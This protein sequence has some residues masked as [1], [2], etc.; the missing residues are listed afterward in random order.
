MERIQELLSEED[1]QKLKS[2][3]K[4]RSLYKR[5][6]VRVRK[7]FGAGVYGYDPLLSDDVIEGFGV[8]AL[9]IAMAAEVLGWAPVVGL[10]VGLKETIRYFEKPIRGSY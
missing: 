3:P 6:I 5:E 2:V 8:K 7:E 10:E 1:V 9:D 4:R